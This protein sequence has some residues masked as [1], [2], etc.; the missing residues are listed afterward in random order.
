MPG[1]ILY[2]PSPEAVTGKEKINPFGIPYGLLSELMAIEVHPLTPLA[3]SLMCSIA[4][5]P[6][7]AALDNFLAAMISAPLL[8][9]F[10]WKNSC[11][12]FWSTKSKTFFAF[13]F[14]RSQHWY[15]GW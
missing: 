11:T 6:A 5:F 15:H 12:H 13:N 3:H 14:C 2:F 1:T 10:G 8:P 4:A 7:E 9:T